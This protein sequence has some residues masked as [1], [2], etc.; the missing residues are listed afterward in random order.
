MKKL[1]IILAAL[2]FSSCT[3]FVSQNL[4]GIIRDTQG[5]SLERIRVRDKAIN[6]KSILSGD[7]DMFVEF[8]A[9]STFIAEYSGNMHRMTVES[10]AFT[11]TRGAVGA[12][13]LTELPGAYPIETGFM[14]RRN[15]SLCQF[16]KEQVIIS[17]K[18]QKAAGMEAA[19]KLAGELAKHIGTSG[20]DPEIYRT[21]PTSN[22]I[23]DSEYYFMGSRS[24]KLRFPAN[25]ADDLAIPVARE[26][27]SANYDPGDGAVT[28]FKIR[29]PS[30]A[31][32]KDALNAYLKKH[33]DRPVITPRESLQYYTIIE[34]DRKETYIADYADWLYFMANCPPEGKSR[35]FMEF[36]LRGGR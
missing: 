32:A 34:K 7:K 3:M 13:K 19:Q 24:F 11:S 12:F 20:L 6:L 4:N 21:L 23:A 27:W 36:I 15:D 16:V 31:I 33:G 18:P 28:L 25:L 9:D 14:G 35:Q 1:V 17:V 22:R 26:G 5:F 10:V 8:G 30:P 29:F 2:L